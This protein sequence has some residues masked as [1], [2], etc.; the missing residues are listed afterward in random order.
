MFKTLNFRDKKSAIAWMLSLAL[1]LVLI[2]Y[3]A[4]PVNTS[5]GWQ[6]EVIWNQL[7]DISALYFKPQEGLYIVIKKTEKGEK[8]PKTTI[9]L[10]NPLN[11]EKKQLAASPKN[12]SLK[13]LINTRNIVLADQSQVILEKSDRQGRLILQRQNE[14][15]IIVRNLHNPSILV[16][17]NNN[18]LYLAEQGRDRILKISHEK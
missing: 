5:K 13:K 2:D 18:V 12:L 6:K 3:Y 4:G 14:Q 9:L 8:T 7:E 10:Y 11:S 16:K 1:A 15:D 17:G